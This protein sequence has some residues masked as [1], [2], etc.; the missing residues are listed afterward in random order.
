MALTLNLSST[1]GTS[2]NQ[3]KL[4]PW[5]IHEVIFKGIVYSEFKNKNDEANPYQVM[6]ITFGNENGIYEETVFA[7][8][9]GDEVRRTNTVKGVEKESPSNYE[10]FRFLLAHIGEQ[11][12]PKNYEKFKG[13][14]F[15]LPDEFKKLVETFA[16]VVAPAVD[17][18]TKLKLIANKKGEACLPFFV[19]LNKEGEAYIS[20][21]FLGEK[22]FFSEYE[23]TSMEKQKS[24]KPTDMSSASTDDLSAGET[25]ATNNGDLDFDV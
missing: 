25:A 18:S 1:K 2:N 17:K 15:S 10:R 3:P 24:A 13:M 12:A 16:K 21:N 14:T 4:K 23:L 20:N 7:P 5:E 22:A 8:K 11:L 6:K 19:N 9:D